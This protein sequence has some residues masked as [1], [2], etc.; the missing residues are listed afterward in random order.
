ML[1]EICRYATSEC[2]FMAGEEIFRRGARSE[3]VLVLSGGKVSYSA[4]EQE[5]KQQALDVNVGQW[6]C[7]HCLW[8]PW[9]HHGRLESK[10]LSLCVLINSKNFCSVIEQWPREV[11][12]CQY[13]AQLWLAN[14]RK[15]FELGE[16][17]AVHDLFFSKSLL[18]HLARAAVSYMDSLG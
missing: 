7:E 6:L 18:Q 2:Q 16:D 15:V 9:H 14:I 8:I 4:G 11:R 13:Y 5:G 3:D 12:C 17:G 1:K 10:E